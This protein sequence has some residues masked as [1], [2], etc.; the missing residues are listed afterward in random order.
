MIKGYSRTITVKRA[1][2]G[3]LFFLKGA[4]KLYCDSQ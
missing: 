1:D 2:G 3:A 4:M